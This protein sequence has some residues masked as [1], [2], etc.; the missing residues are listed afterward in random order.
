VDCAAFGEDEVSFGLDT[1]AF[2][3]SRDGKSF[4]IGTLLFQDWDVVLSWQCTIE[5]TN[6]DLLLRHESQPDLRLGYIK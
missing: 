1:Y 2:Y 4:L 6:A 3:C 5:L